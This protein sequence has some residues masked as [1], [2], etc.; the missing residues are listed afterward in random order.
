MSVIIEFAL[1]RSNE[2]EK[3][4]KGS[5][6][7]AYMTVVNSLISFVGRN[8]LTFDELTPELL[9]RFEQHLFSEN[10]EYNTV[11]V[12]MR[13][14]RALCNRAPRSRT[15]ISVSELF[16]DVFTGSVSSRS[17]S[18]SLGIIRKMAEADLDT[19]RTEL[20]FA[21]DM[22]VLSFYLCGIPFVDLAHLRKND[23]QD[24]RISYCRRKTGNSVMVVVEPCALNIIRRYA[25]DCHYSSYLLPIL[26]DTSMNDF[27]HYQS[28]LR[29]YNKR[30]DRLS[31]LLQLDEKVTSYTPRHTWST[32]AHH[33]GVNIGLIRQ[34]LGHSSEAM[35]RRYLSDFGAGALQEATRMMIAQLQYVGREQSENEYSGKKLQRKSLLREWAY[36]LKSWWKNSIKLK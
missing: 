36:S 18:V 33:S 20:A 27:Q 35:T 4:G 32:L 29:V 5:A 23:L 22:F 19:Q 17:R 3:A 2:C 34:V 11:S 9:K 13:M 15:A 30:L 12:Y 10:L 28:A 6:A 24:G 7:R 1:S 21:R 16:K 8:D 14:L 31:T 26:K 25:P